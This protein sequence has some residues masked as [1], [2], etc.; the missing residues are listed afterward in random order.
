MTAKFIVQHI[1]YPTT[2]AIDES[3]WKTY[4]THKTESAAWK[5]IAKAKAHLDSAQ[6]DDHYRVIDIAGLRC[7]NRLGL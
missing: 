4:S 6:W 1:G 3:S 2:Q 7:W 5:R